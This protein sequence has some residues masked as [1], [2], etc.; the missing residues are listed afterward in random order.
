MQVVR[1][2]KEWWQLEIM[3][4]RL[5]RNSGY[6]RELKVIV[7]FLYD[8]VARFQVTNNNMGFY[9]ASEHT[10]S[11]SARAVEDDRLSGCLEH[12]RVVEDGCG[13][14]DDDDER[15]TRNR[16]GIKSQISRTISPQSHLLY[17]WRSAASTEITFYFR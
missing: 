16:G 7:R 3:E 8:G 11:K 13:G 12:V 9:S 6:V 1:A 14:V 10:T 17:P 4:R 2:G 15:R 5:N